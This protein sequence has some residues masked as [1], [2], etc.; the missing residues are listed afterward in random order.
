MGA[1]MKAVGIALVIAGV[2]AI[3]SGGFSYTSRKDV[4]DMGLI[5]DRNTESRPVRIPPILCL[6]A[7]AAGGALVFFR[8]R[9]RR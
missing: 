1:S 2:I 6:S 9:Q 5:L 4:P 8:I 7:I 3:F